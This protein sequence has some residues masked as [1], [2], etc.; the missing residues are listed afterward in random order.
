MCRN[1]LYLFSFIGGIGVACA[2]ETLTIPLIT[3]LAFWIYYPPVIKKELSRLLALFGDT[4]REYC[5][6]GTILYSSYLTTQAS[7]IILH[8]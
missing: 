3:A 4:Y 8:C 2:T 7:A 5:Q 1:P 6:K